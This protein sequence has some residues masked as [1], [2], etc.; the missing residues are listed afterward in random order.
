MSDGGGVTTSTA[1]PS[2]EPA[3]TAVSRCAPSATVLRLAVF[4]VSGDVR[5]MVPSLLRL[6]ARVAGG[7]ACGASAGPQPDQRLVMLLRHDRWRRVDDL[8]SD[9][10][11][12]PTA[13]RGEPLRAERHGVAPG[14]LGCCRRCSLHGP[15]LLRL[16]ARAVGGVACGPLSRSRPR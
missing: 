16:L 2:P 11:A 15:S 13:D 3:R 4:D 6:L 7:V 5:F 1:I 8:D 10:E 12:V 14:G 9:A